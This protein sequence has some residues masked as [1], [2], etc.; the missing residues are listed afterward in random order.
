VVPTFIPAYQAILAVADALTGV[1]LLGQFYQLRRRS[2]L[3]LSCGYL[4]TA[5]MIVAHTLSFPGLVGPGNLIGGGQ[6]TVWIYIFW[7]VFFPLYV[8]GYAVLERSET[9]RET[10]LKVTEVAGAATLGLALTA[11]LAATCL[12]AV[13]WGHDHLP[14]LMDGNRY[15]PGITRPAVATTRVAALIV[16]VVLLS[17]TRARRILDVWLAVVLGAWLVEILLSA[18]VNSGRFQL[19]FYV[20]RLY[21]LVAACVVLGVLLAETIF[22]YGRLVR[23]IAAERARA[24]ELAHAQRL[25]AVGQL[26]GGLAHDFNNLLTVVIGKLEI[27]RRSPGDAAKVARNAAGAA[28][29]R[30]RRAAYPS[31]ARLREKA[32]YPPEI[33]NP[34]RILTE[35]H[36]LLARAAGEGIE[37][38][39]KLSPVLDPVDVDC[40]QFET[41]IL[42]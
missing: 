13:T 12:L 1:L 14:A 22:L 42:I 2:L 3:V 30:A 6:T 41:A 31:P 33:A 29:S 20:G 23:A 5:A 16:L 18:L 38:Q 7:H 40:A 11:V 34:N 24:I 36:P 26:T 17:R 9:E 37:I 27:I 32:G 39:T 19:G 10:A 35:I 8:I 28:S 4:F 15:I 21:G 25:D